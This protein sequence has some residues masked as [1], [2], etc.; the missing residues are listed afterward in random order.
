MIGID[1]NKKG[2]T[3]V[4]VMVVVSVFSVLF[5]ITTGLFSFALKTQ[6]NI[7]HHQEMISQLS[8][9]A[10]IIASQLRDA[11][12]TPPL[13]VCVEGEDNYSESTQGDEGIRFY[14]RD[15]LCV[16]IYR[17]DTV[18][19]VGSPESGE[20]I[21]L[22]PKPIFIED[23]KVTIQNPGMN[24]SG[25][26]R[27]TFMIKAKGPYPYEKEMTLVRTVSQ[28]NLNIGPTGPTIP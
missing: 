28:R 9:T 20:A 3:L 15:N 25:Q 26:A 12:I 22:T 18:L 6:R 10:D 5:T 7:R 16:E 21:P 14:S 27:V 11:K 4:E 23:F 19:L 13:E 24:D 17:K 8:Y 1:Q 2:F